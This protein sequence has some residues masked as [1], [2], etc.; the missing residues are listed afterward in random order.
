MWL[1]P[2]TSKAC[3]REGRS[4]PIDDVCNDFTSIEFTRDHL[5]DDD[6]RWHAVPFS[7][8]TRL[9]IL[10]LLSLDKNL[11]QS[12]EGEY[13]RFLSLRR[14]FNEHVATF[15]HERWLLCVRVDSL[16]KQ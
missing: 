13:V 4:L 11:P 7:E 10:K 15:R 3:A 1:I 2:K 14:F 12:P 9:T 8:D 6:R 5:F 16:L